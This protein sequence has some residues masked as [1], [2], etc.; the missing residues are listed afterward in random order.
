[1][2]LCITNQGLAPTNWI[3]G[4]FLLNNNQQKCMDVS[5]YLSIMNARVLCF[6]AHVHTFSKFPVLDEMGG[7][8]WS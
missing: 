6:R 4:F 5:I 8:S 7:Q 3:V 1:M 2:L